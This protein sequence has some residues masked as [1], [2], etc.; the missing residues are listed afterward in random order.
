MCVSGTVTGEC[1]TVI[2][3]PV[4]DVAPCKCV[5]QADVL[6]SNASV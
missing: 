2:R 1:L 5:V 3:S 4:C 6:S